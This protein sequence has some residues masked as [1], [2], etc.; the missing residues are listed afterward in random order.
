MQK[1]KRV[2]FTLVL[3]TMLGVLPAFTSSAAS[4]LPGNVTKL[5]KSKQ[6]ETS[7]DL[8][9][10]R[11]TNASG[12]IIYRVD[13]ATGAQKKVATTTKTSYTV[14]NLKIDQTYQYQVF[15]YRKYKG[16]TYYSAKGSPVVTVKTKAL[17]PTKVKNFR[18][19]GF[20]NK[21]LTLK[22]DAATN[23]DAY[24]VYMYNSDTKKYEKA[25]K[26]KKTSY[27]VSD[28][29]AGVTYRFRVQAYH[30]VQGT[31]T[32]GDFSESAKGTAK[33]INIS[34]VHGRYYNATVKSD[35]TVKVI[36]TGKTMRLKKGTKVVT[37]D[38]RQKSNVTAIL[39]NKTQVTIYGGKLNYTSLN[40]TKKYYS[41][42]TMEDFINAKG[43]SSPTSYLI[44]V[45]Q[46][47]MSTNVFK[48]YEGHWK[49]VRSGPC[50]IG[51]NGNTPQRVFHI[52]RKDRRYGGPMVYIAWF[53]PE[54][55]G[56]GFHRRT[57]P[58]ITRA[59]VSGGC[60]RLS[61]SD[62]N[63]INNNCPIGT[64]VVSY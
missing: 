22:W 41:K 14:K 15:A 58:G 1:L 7:V 19:A 56:Y 27:V 44:W 59:A 30:T 24:I 63:F 51:K 62:L 21:E 37:T 50:V 43:Y 34:G 8:S 23:A 64:T 13:T 36:S 39:N 31:T 5:S 25:G 35:T 17:V 53:G 33:K 52:V 48:G 4:K 11:A 42:Q 2:L 28:L 55:G 40:T 26:T 38:R 45:S 54:T 9:W 47:T 57:Q 46:Y 16:K 6:A 32:F 20:G 60:I 12:Y 10:K 29:T 3:M 18:V 49:L 61:D